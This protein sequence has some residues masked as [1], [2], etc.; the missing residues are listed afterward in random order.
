M[1]RIIS[2]NL[3]DS[4]LL[5]FFSIEIKSV[6][7]FVIRGIPFTF[8]AKKRLPRIAL[9]NTNEKIMYIYDKNNS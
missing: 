2:E 8:I 4:W 9:I 6:K 1:T 7:I 3:C 5:L